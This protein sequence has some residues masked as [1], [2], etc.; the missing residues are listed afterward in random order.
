MLSAQELA[1]KAIDFLE[2][3]FDFRLPDLT[4]DSE[5]E[6]LQ[7]EVLNLRAQL[8]AHDAR[9]FF[10][11]PTTPIQE[12]DSIGVSIN[13]VNASFDDVLEYNIDEFKELG[14][15]SMEDM[16]KIWA[17]ECGHRILQNLNLSPWASELGADFFAG[18][19]SE[20]LGIPRGQFEESMVAL[21][22]S[23]SHPGGDLRIQAMD[24]G[25]IFV[26]AMRQRGMEPN[27]H[28][29]IAAFQMS[30]YANIATESTTGIYQPSPYWNQPSVDDAE[31]I[32]IP[33]L[34]EADYAELQYDTKAWLPGHEDLESVDPPQRAIFEP[35]GMG[36]TIVTDILGRRVHYFNSQEAY[37][38]C[39]VFSGFHANEHTWDASIA[40]NEEKLKR[41]AELET[42]RDDAVEKYHNAVSMGDTSGAE[43]WKSKANSCE[44]MLNSHWGV[45]NYGLDVTA[46]GL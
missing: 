43:W 20:M 25:R 38:M 6:A 34:S 40:M 29:C 4:K 8:S 39:D 46:K 17:H 9:D 31:F 18:V 27:L 15:T 14:C 5:K 3:G 10:H 13:D 30:P 16:T 23:D 37:E 21:P 41:G 26:D 45:S 19:R 11:L 28:Q 12:G 36:G 1:S 32:T 42:Q 33:P 35:D 24:F 22:A 44:S 2:S 7:D